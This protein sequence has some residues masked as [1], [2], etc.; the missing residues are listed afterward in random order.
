[1]G[2]ALQ[3]LAELNKLTWV[4]G[5]W[6]DKSGRP[7]TWAPHKAAV[8]ACKDPGEPFR[9]I[10]LIPIC[11]ACM[12]QCRKWLCSPLC[13]LDLYLRPILL[14]RQVCLR[15]RWCQNSLYSCRHVWKI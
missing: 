12:V 9:D 6:E 11:S 4:H 14:Q 5:P 10:K 8:S 13:W 7:R 2:Q 15:S 1:M 3:K